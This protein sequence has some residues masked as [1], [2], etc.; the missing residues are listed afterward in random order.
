MQTKTLARGN[1]L[2]EILVVLVILVLLSG[3]GYQYLVGGKNAKGEKAK[4]PMQAGKSTACLMNLDQVRKGI[5]TFKT[6]ETEEKLPASLDDLKFPHESLICPDSK[7]PY[8]YDASNGQVHCPTPG[9]E[10]N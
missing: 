3:I 8:Q 6:S 7:Q 4:T 1:T 5:E 9:H 10:K 2:V